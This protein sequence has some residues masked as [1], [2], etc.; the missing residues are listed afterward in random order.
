MVWLRRVV[1]AVALQLS[2]VVVPAA[3]VAQ[4][5]APVDS[6]PLA[7]A[8]ASGQRVELPELTTSTGQ[9]FVNPDG[10]TTM[11][12]H[13]QPVRGRK[14]G[15]WVPV[16]TS[17]RFNE[18]AVVQNAGAVQVAFSAGGSAALVRLSD[19]D[20]FVEMTWPRPLPR[21]ELSGDTALYRDVLPGVDLRLRAVPQGFAKVLVVKD[22][23]AAANPELARLSFGVRAQGLT[24]RRTDGGTIEAVASDGQQVFYAGKPRMWDADRAKEADIPTELADDRITITPDAA[25]LAAPDTRYPVEIDP[26]WGAGRAAWMLAYGYPSHLNGNTYWFGDG[27]NIAKVGYTNRGDGKNPTVM[28]RSYFQFDTSSLIGKHILSAEFNAREIYAPT[29]TP[30]EVGLHEVGAINSGMSWNT[31]PW[32]GQQVDRLNVAFGYNASCPSK[33]LGFQAFGAVINAVNTRSSTTTLM[34]KAVDEGSGGS[35]SWKKFDPNTVS[36][37]VTYNSVPNAPLYKTTDGH[38]CTLVPAQAWIR[39]SGPRITA[40]PTDPDGGTVQVKFEWFVRGGAKKG[41]TTTQGQ[42]SGTRFGI[43]IPKTAFKDGDTISWRAQTWDG[44]DWSPWSNS[45]EATV[46]TTRPNATPLVSSPDFPKDGIGGGVG[47]TGRFV[48]E[49]NGVADVAAYL[50]DFH[51]Q[52]QRRV[53]AGPDGKATALV[54]PTEDRPYD[55]YVRSVDRAG[56]PSDLATPYHFRP[57]AGAPPVG[58]WH[59]NGQYGDT[60]A[61]DSSGKGNNGKLGGSAPNA[62]TIGRQDDA[63]VFDGNGYVATTKPAVRTDATFAVSAWVRA[64]ALDSVWRT[65]VSQDGPNVSAFTVQMDPTSHKWRFMMPSTSAQDSPRTVAESDLAAVVGRWTHLVGMFDQS[66]KRVSLYVDGVLQASSGTQATPWNATGNVQLGRAWYAGKYVDQ[67]RGALD[68]VRVYDRLLS[69]DEIDALATSPTASEGFW[70]F[71]GDPRDHSGNNRV[72]TTSG[73]TSWSDLAAVGSGSLEL[74]G[75]SGQVTTGK[76]AVRT[77]NSF[78]VSAYVRL[79]GETGDWQVPVSQDGPKASGFSLRYRSDTKRWSFAVS[80]ADANTPV[81]LGADSPQEATVGEWTLLTGVYDEAKRQVRLYVNSARVTVTPIAPDVH[82]THVPGAFV[83]GRGKL[84]GAEARFFKGFVDHV[85]VYT[86]VRTDDQIQED[87]RTPPR[88]AQTLYSGQ[89]SRWV[90]NGAPHLLTLGQ[91]VRGGRFEGSLGFPADEGAPNTVMLNQCLT[92]G[93]DEFAS[94]DASCEGSRLVGPIGLLYSTPPTDVPVSAI[95]ACKVAA[96]GERFETPDQGCD[97]HVRVSVLGYAKALERLVRYREIDGQGEFR[98]GAHK[99]PTS[100]TPDITLGVIPM[101]GLP[102]TVALRVCQNG[103]DTFLSVQPDCEGKNLVEVTGSIWPAPPAGR[104]TVELL[105]CRTGSGDLFE[106]VDPGCEGQTRDRS[107]GYVLP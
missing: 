82:F 95:Y 105:R 9:A 64:D 91:P 87:S 50:Y 103:T 27:D 32:E 56:N 38:D 62:W 18:S 24:V 79:M 19:G 1:T 73:N 23:T 46:D 15:Q 30:H 61:F 92:G 90:G 7:R 55:L 52:P 45:C 86:G 101:Y 40:I 43:D 42:A 25:M 63:L 16:D 70:T 93:G 77:D 69:E 4:Q 97:G 58:L 8:K 104:D 35:D 72:G 68:E 100:Y 49:P 78:T 53:E 12:Q 85:T 33:Y 102:D 36:L 94:V 39:G 88:P 13:V 89:F 75:V 106:S 54:T 66:S 48:F 57:G 31:R 98:S 80:T 29:C 3:A 37:N 81:T 41:E 76:Q 14:D 22:R 60:D 67:F 20:R 2:L 47:H 11:E 51:D 65:V 59:L 34:L 84:N 44:T 107:L 10:T 99:M 96:S 6:S 83:I 28:I 5:A 21:P 26:D 17:L 74:D 71:D